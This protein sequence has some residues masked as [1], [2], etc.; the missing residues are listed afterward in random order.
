MIISNSEI[1]KSANV[2]LV[3]FILIKKTVHLNTCSSWTNVEKTE[4]VRL[5]LQMSVPSS[6]QQC[7]PACAVPLC[8]YVKLTCAAQAQ[9]LAHVIRVVGWVPA[10]ALLYKAGGTWLPR[11]T[12]IAVRCGRSAV[13]ACQRYLRVHRCSLVSPNPWTC[14]P[15]GVSSAGN[16][17]R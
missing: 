9:W 4:C 6:A 15:A 11:S 5:P 7:Y 17:A 10:F 12:A 14:Q 2:K 13:T 3:F 1:Y 16:T 8:W